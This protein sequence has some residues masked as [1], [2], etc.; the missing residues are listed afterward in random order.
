MGAD[1]FVPI[2]T[3]LLGLGGSVFGTTQQSKAA[4]EAKKAQAQQAAEQKK[5]ISQQRQKEEEERRR[6]LQ[7]QRMRMLAAGQ[8][9]PRSTIMTSPLGIVG[10]QGYTGAGPTLLG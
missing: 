5:L 10:G 4:E 2:I 6:D 3:S 8:T 1:V 9:V 7:R